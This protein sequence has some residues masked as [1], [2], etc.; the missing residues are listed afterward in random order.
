MSPETGVSTTAAPVDA[1]VVP[2]RSVFMGGG[3]VSPDDE[4]P[5]DVVDP[6]TERIIGTVL[7]ASADLAHRALLDARE[8]WPA[9]A[10]LPPSRRAGLLDALAAE[11]ERHGDALAELATHEIGMPIRESRAVQVDLPVKVLR[12]TAAIARQLAWDS[13]DASGSSVVREPVGV[14]LAITPWNFPVH[15]IVAK[16]A[17]ALAAGCTV[18]LKPAELTP[19][20][21]LFLAELGRRAG[22][23]AGVFDVVTGTGAT[24]GEA[25]LQDETW[26]MV[27]FTGS[28]AVGR[29]IGAVAGSRIKRATLELGGKSPAVVLDD[30]DLDLAVRTTVRNC[31]TNAGQKCNAPTRLLVPADRL[32]D[33]V[34]IAAE[35]AD[36]YVL[37]DPL[38]PGTTMG[39][40]VSAEQRAKVL[41]FVD[42]ARAAGATVATGGTAVDGT[43]FFLRPTIVTD[44]AED[45]EIVREEVFG[46]VLVVQGH[47]GE[48]DAVRMANDTPYGLSSEVWSADE[49]RAAA[50]ARRI[51]AGQVRVNGVR[52]PALPVSPFGGYGQSGL[53]REMGP[54]AIEEYLEVKA[55]LGDPVL[56]PTATTAAPAAAGQDPLA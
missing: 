18:V 51:R 16:L 47:A 9:W 40:V 53:G 29:H 1:V 5:L 20:N 6:A 44:L 17:P 25:L 2:D 50:I 45:A 42:T 49:V 35:S 37:G 48:D 7:D 23:P 22:L 11:L 14:V 28:L 3:W 12:S 31:F 24:T 4:A 15:Q 43:G 21:A 55:V 38:D 34:R 41:R 32:H 8:A 52:T 13:R 19:L 46:P 27:S 39:P 36:A 56:D 54:F 30:A 10:A 33:A 26:D